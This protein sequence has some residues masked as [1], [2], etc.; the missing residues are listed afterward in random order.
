MLGQR[1]LRTLF[2]YFQIWSTAL[3][4]ALFWWP[5]FILLPWLN[6]CIGNL[7]ND[8]TYLRLL[9]SFALIVPP[10]GNGLVFEHTSDTNCLAISKSKSSALNSAYNKA[11][12][13]LQ[14]H[15]ILLYHAFNNC[16]LASSHIACSYT[17]LI[18]CDTNKNRLPLISE[19]NFSFKPK[20]L[21]ACLILFYSAAGC[22]VVT[23]TWHNSL[24][25]FQFFIVLS[26]IHLIP[27][28]LLAISQIQNSRL[29]TFN[30]RCGTVHRCIV[31]DSKIQWPREWHHSLRWTYF[32]F[33][34][35]EISKDFQTHNLQ[36]NKQQKKG[37]A[38]LSCKS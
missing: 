32:W 3:T 28:M 19:A 24:V 21:P 37:C 30:S 31:F 22:L 14:R 7:P 9:L 10:V 33:P 13:S 20:S 38:F 1:D 34:V 6:F 27:W 5:C 36:R 35:M 23:K 2:K 12:K 4:L 26:Q 29:P 18:L 11:T 16:P 17:L 15:L 8:L 25:K